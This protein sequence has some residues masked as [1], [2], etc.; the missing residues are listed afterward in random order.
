MG[1]LGLY[2]WNYPYLY[3]LEA[4]EKGM[5]DKHLKLEKLADFLYTG[6]EYPMRRFNS[7]YQGNPHLWKYYHF[8]NFVLPM[9]F[10]QPEYMMIPIIEKVGSYSHLGYKITNRAADTLVEVEVGKVDKF[11]IENDAQ[12]LFNLPIFKNYIFA[13]PIEEIWKDLFLKKIKIYSDVGTIPLSELKELHQIP[14]KELAYN[15]FILHLRST[16]LPKNVKAFGLFSDRNIGVVETTQKNM[17]AEVILFL[18]KG[19]VYRLNLQTKPYL[20][21]PDLIRHLIFKNLNFKLDS[22]DDQITLYAEHQALSFEDRFTQRGLVVLF[23]AFSHEITNEKMLSEMIRY[24]ERGRADSIQIRP[25]Y[26]YAYTQYGTN[27]SE[28]DFYRKENTDQFLKRK[29]E[30]EMEKEK[31]EDVLE[32]KDH[33]ESEEEKIKAYLNNAKNSKNKDQNQ[34]IIQG[35]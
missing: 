8:Q 3:Y 11:S 5:Y 1:L 14:L 2:A 27:F 6:G 7:D 19:M 9:P 20:D 21:E 33:F 34:N 12:W 17:F 15:L 30:E 35:N 32:K 31:E 24:L 23:S 16:F 10:D 22:A 28:M 13:K 26:D 25:L 4:I 29:A 18:H